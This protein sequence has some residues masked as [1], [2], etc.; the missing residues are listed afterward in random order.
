MEEQDEAVHRWLAE[1]TRAMKKVTALTE[2]LAEEQVI[3]TTCINELVSVRGDRD[4][5]TMELVS[6]RA[7]HTHVIADNEALINRQARI[8]REER[9]GDNLTEEARSEIRADFA[10][11]KITKD[12]LAQDHGIRVALVSFIVQDI[13]PGATDLDTA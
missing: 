3:A 9:T 2:E 1:R 12:Q 7:A 10:G 8:E 6:V 4:A 11:G 13:V 5:L